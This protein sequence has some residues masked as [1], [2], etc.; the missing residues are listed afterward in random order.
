MKISVAS[1]IYPRHVQ[2]AL[3]EALLSG[4]SV[5]VVLK[6]KRHFEEEYFDNFEVELDIER[7]RLRVLSTKTIIEEVS[8]SD[9]QI[10]LR[11]VRSEATRR[12]LLF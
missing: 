6:T 11:E 2:S 5:I 1:A 8:N 9:H 12:P 10:S 7:R 4:T 3:R